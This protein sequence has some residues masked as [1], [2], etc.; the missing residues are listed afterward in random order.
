MPGSPSASWSLYKARLE[1]VVDEVDIPV[2]AAF[3]LFGK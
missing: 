1:A 3:W 2:C